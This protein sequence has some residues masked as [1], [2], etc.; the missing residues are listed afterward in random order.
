[1]T[2]PGTN[3]EALAKRVAKRVNFMV[4]R[5]CCSC[6][7]EW[8]SKDREEEMSTT[9]DAHQ[10]YIGDAPVLDSAGSSSCCEYWCCGCIKYRGDGGVVR[11]SRGGH[12][13]KVYEVD[14]NP[15]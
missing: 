5:A 15:R 14:L 3:A 12:N 2:A 13:H 8:V 6:G 10:F 1:M 4:L 7:E 11:V 9:A